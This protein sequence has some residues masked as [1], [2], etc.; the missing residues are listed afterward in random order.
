MA[1]AALRNQVMNYRETFQS[2]SKNLAAVASSTRA[3]ANKY[4]LKKVP[5][6]PSP[7]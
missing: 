4:L 3:D 2:L 7:V 6:K 5:L 1:E